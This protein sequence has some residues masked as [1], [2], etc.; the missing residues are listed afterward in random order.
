MYI[1][2]M[3]SEDAASLS[4][5]NWRKET[6]GII[7]QYYHDLYFSFAGIELVFLIDIQSLQSKSLIGR[8]SGEEYYSKSAWKNKT[9][10]QYWSTQIYK[11]SSCIS[12]YKYDV[13]R[14]VGWQVSLGTASVTVIR[15]LLV[16]M[17]NGARPSR[18]TAQ[19]N[20]YIKPLPKT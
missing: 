16:S 14:V 7:I 9:Q 1:G 8:T 6:A 17:K 12:F 18:Q 20:I 2:D 10:L 5:L 19:G 11:L 4:S 15:H 13:W 3:K